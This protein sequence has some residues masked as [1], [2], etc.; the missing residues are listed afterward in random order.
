MPI[1]DYATGALGTFGAV[2][3]LRSRNLTGH[4]QQ[5]HGSLA[6]TASLLQAQELYET[7]AGDRRPAGP[8]SQSLCTVKCSDGWM[9]FSKAAALQALKVRPAEIRT[10]LVDAGAV[11]PAKLGL[12]MFQATLATL[13][14]EKAL[15]VLGEL[16]LAGASERHWRDLISLDWIREAGL[17][18]DWTHPSWGPMTQGVPQGTT[19][20]FRLRAGWPAPDPGADT[21]AVLTE[22]DFTPTEIEQLLESGAIAGRTPLFSEDL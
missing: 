9:T 14:R 16:G 2:L 10:R 13:P 6:R 8:E 18:V 21:R 20:D 19:E 17:V 11:P 22:A 12:R 3:A 4:G 15:V 5:V 7:A 1:D